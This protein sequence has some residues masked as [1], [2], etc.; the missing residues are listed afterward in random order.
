MLVFVNRIASLKANAEFIEAFVHVFHVFKCQVYSILLGVRD[1]SVRSDCKRN[2]LPEDNKRRHSNILLES[3]FKQYF[4]QHFSHIHSII[5]YGT[6]FD[7]KLRANVNHLL[8][9][10]VFRFW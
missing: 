2:E 8:I 9:I 10:G 7:K 1:K 4:I 3:W 6:G 5:L